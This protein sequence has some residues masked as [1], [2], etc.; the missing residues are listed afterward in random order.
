MPG[1][2]RLT[3]NQGQTEV[4]E[5]VWKNEAGTP[6]DISTWTASA[7][8]RKLQTDAVPAWQL[9]TGAGTIVIDGP[10]GKLT[11]TWSAIVTAALEAGPGVWDLELYSP[12]GSVKRLLSGPY[13]VTPEVTH[14]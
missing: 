1:L 11:L 13:M 4:R 14:A 12:G 10:A 9:S 6:Y 2:Y 7:T 3:L 8:G 5:V